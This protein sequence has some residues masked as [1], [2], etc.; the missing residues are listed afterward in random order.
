MTAHI[1]VVDDD[2]TICDVI[3]IQLT[4]QGHD[5]T[6]VSNGV[7]ALAHV[8]THDDVA[9]VIMDIM[10]P[11]MNGIDAC[12][13]IRKLSSVPVLF[14][15]ARAGDADKKDAYQ[16]GGDD[17]LI[18]PFSELD[19]TLKVEALLRRYR[20]YQGQE[21]ADANELRVGNFMIDLQTHD[22]TVGDERIVLTEMEYRLFAFLAE[23]RGSVQD[24]R[25]I[26]E[27]VW[28]DR[29]LPSSSNTVMVHIV[30]LRKKLEPHDGREIIHT[31]WGRGYQID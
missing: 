11:A 2:P 3:K 20:V 8:Q 27:N 16:N 31:V 28:Q 29:Y 10:M 6:C 23:H 30:R 1:L 18:K 7:Q 13:E 19:L 15:T 24:A 14:L 9:L 26:Y 22:V 25:T 5:V 4:S 12:K 17:Y 21:A